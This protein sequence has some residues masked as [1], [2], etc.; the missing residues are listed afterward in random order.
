M[1]SLSH[2]SSW[3]SDWQGLRVAVIGLGVTGFSAADTL[4][5]LG[6]EVAVFAEKAEDDYLD[7]LDVLGVDLLLLV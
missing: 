5:E 7:I 2:L 3:H 4:A 1:A 6:C